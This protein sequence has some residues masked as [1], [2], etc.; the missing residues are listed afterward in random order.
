MKRRIIVL[1]A[2]LLLIATNLYAGS[3][4]V[5]VEG[6]LGVGTNTPAARMHVTNGN[7]VVD[8][9]VG[10]G[11]SA[12]DGN[13]KL[14]VEGPVGAT[15]YCDQNGSNCA[16]PPLQHTISATCSTGIQEI[17]P[18]GTVICV[19]ATTYLSTG[20]Y[21]ICSSDPNGEPAYCTYRTPAFCSSNQCS[22]PSG[23][24]RVLLSS[25]KWSDTT[26]NE[27]TYSCYKN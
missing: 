17:R 7:A 20:L 5:F 27:G 11:D 2:G 10:I 12:P 21:G 15:Q 18:D 3:G 8:G 14:D 6:N 16:T 1:I 4:D 25:N 22:C 23:F 26:N 13:L 19:T 9:T 24:T